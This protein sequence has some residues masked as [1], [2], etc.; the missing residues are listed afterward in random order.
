[1]KKVLT[2]NSIKVHPNLKQI[3]TQN[4]YQ[5]GYQLKYSK[6]TPSTHPPNICVRVKALK[7][8][9]TVLGLGEKENYERKKPELGYKNTSDHVNGL[10]CK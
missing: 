9:M 1:M 3:I 7:G 5:T 4:I 6:S 10:K 8:R 2:W